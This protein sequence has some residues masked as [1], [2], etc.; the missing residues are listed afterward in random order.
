MSLPTDTTGY[1]SY[2]GP[3]DVPDDVDDH[4]STTS[5]NGSGPNGGIA[6]SGPETDTFTEIDFW[7]EMEQ[8]MSD[9]LRR[10]SREIERTTDTSSGFLVNLHL[11]DSD[12]SEAVFSAIRRLEASTPEAVPSAM[13]TLI[14]QIQDADEA[15]E[16]ARAE[17]LRTASRLF[18][19]DNEAERLVPE[20]ENNAISSDG[21]VAGPSSERLLFHDSL[22]DTWDPRPTR[23]ARRTPALAQLWA[24]HSLFEQVLAR[25]RE[26]TPVE[27]EAAWLASLRALEGVTTPPSPS[28]DPEGQ[29]CT[30][31][32][33]QIDLGLEYYFGSLVE[34]DEEEQE[35]CKRHGK[36]RAHLQ[37]SVME[38][39]E[40]EEEEYTG[41]GK[42][43]SHRQ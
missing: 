35:P 21:P 5:S 26:E 27:R 3:L 16:C 8:L 25:S 40:E 17:R 32:D 39:E 23:T 12:F 15:N 30:P 37:C 9:S 43:R 6:L 18:L 2:H 28:G 22:A 31:D 10:D 14:H 4:A 38:E 42:G 7:E 41:K 29:N 13:A 24:E 20:P 33:E 11:D 1:R 34:E 19:L 36:G